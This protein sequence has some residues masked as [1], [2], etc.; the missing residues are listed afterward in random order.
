MNKAT[1]SFF[2]WNKE[3]WIV[4]WQ[5]LECINQAQFADIAKLYVKYN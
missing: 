2:N 4:V 5:I 3:N 1:E